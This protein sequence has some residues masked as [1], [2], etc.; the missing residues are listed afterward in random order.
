MN[1]S[2]KDAAKELKMDLFE[3]VELASAREI[4]FQLE[5]GRPHFSDDEVLNYLINHQPPEPEQIIG[6]EEPERAERGEEQRAAAE[7][8]VAGKAIKEDELLVSRIDYLTGLLHYDEDAA[9]ELASKPTI[10]SPEELERRITRLKSIFSLSNFQNGERGAIVASLFHAN[11]ELLEASFSFHKYEGRLGLAVRALQESYPENLPEEFDYVQHPERFAT[12]EDLKAVNKELR[13]IKPEATPNDEDQLSPEYDSSLIQR[14]EAE[15][16]DFKMLDNIIWHG[17]R[18]QSKIKPFGDSFIPEKH[19]Q[20]RVARCYRGGLTR[21]RSRLYKK[22]FNQLVQDGVI[23]VASGRSQGKCYFLASL[24]ERSLPEY[25]MPYLMKVYGYEV[26]DFERAS[27]ER[28]YSVPSG[29]FRETSEIDG[30]KGTEG[31]N[32]VNPT[33]NGNSGSGSGLP[34]KS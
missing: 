13:G 1:L 33:A 6:D 8:V 4:G 28:A 3:L 27:G 12:L 16:I 21:E 9:T 7:E 2:L 23:K 18:P 11:P 15:G 30:T 24:S 34:S 20:K 10:V 26:P 5:A 22:F 19:I 25:L 14:I 29:T 31:A 17:F 32:K